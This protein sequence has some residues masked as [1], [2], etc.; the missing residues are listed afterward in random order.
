MLVYGSTMAAVSAALQADRMGADVV[1]LSSEQHLGGMTTAGLGGTDVKYGSAI[2]GIASEFYEAVYAHYL[3]PS[4]WNSAT[5]REEFTTVQAQPGRAISEK[6]KRMWHFEPHVASSIVDGWLKESRIRVITGRLDRERGVSLDDARISKIR[7]EDGA[8]I[9]ASMFID[10]TYEGDLM[11][12]AGVPYR[13]GREGQD[14]FDE[15]L[16]GVALNADEFSGISPYRVADDPGSGLL[17]IIESTIERSDIGSP[18]PDIQAYCFRLCMSDDPMNQ[19]PFSQ[20]KGYRADDFE[21]LFRFLDRN[22]KT[23]P[24]KVSTA[25]PNSKIDANN[26]SWFSFDFVGGNRTASGVRWAEADY[27]QRQEIWNAHQR[28]QMSF[29]WAVRNEKR[30]PNGVREIANAW[31]LAAD[32]FKDSAGWPHQLYV[33]EARRMIGAD[34]VTQRHQTNPAKTAVK[35][36]IGMGSYAMDSHAVRRVVV[37]G[38]IYNEGGFYRGLSRPWA[39]PYGAI[40][41]QRNTVSNLVVTCAVSTTHVAYG[42]LRMEPTYMIIGQA[43]GAAAVLAHDGDVGVQDL[44]YRDLALELEKQGQVL[45]EY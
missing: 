33:R 36:S 30:V 41:P 31:G 5:G 24:F 18:S 3:D 23:D 29:L 34:T 39:I 9:Q 38:R 2:G 35:D 40:V 26:A 7:S 14:E 19:V 16:A 6:S 12:A 13:L 45:T 10:A 4:S 37:D 28:Y 25:I 32:E 11:A 20:P 42:S 21:L 43:A 17:P 22:R 44:P 15:S 27:A 8:E 1:L